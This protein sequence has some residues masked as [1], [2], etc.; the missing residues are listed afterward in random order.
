MFTI[1]KNNPVQRP[2]SY[3]ELESLAFETST[4]DSIAKQHLCLLLK[5]KEYIPND[6]YRIDTLNRS[7]CLYLT[8]NGKVIYSEVA[9]M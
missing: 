9:L 7:E 1:L 4:K 2:I 3:N 6:T 5:L 8:E